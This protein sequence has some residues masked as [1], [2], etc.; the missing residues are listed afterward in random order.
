MAKLSREYT[1]H[2]CRATTVHVLDEAQVPRR[3]IMSV[4]GQKSES[5]L[6][7]YTGKICE[8]NKMFMSETISEKTLG[9]SSN[10]SNISE[11]DS[12][13]DNIDFL[14]LFQSNITVE[15]DENTGASISSA[16]SF[17]LQALSNSQTENVLK[18]L[19]PDNDGFDD[20]VKVLDIPQQHQNNVANKSSQ[21]LTDQSPAPFVNN[22]QHITINY[23]IFQRQ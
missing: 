7:T 21:S 12:L 4:T 23:N 15:V 1:N 10:T 3:H 11:H 17:E 13:P 18:N 19:L 22:C 8:K 6:K 9:K 2:S 20:L 16:S 14:A 5:S